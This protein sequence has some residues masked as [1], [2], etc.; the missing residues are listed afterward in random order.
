MKDPRRKIAKKIIEQAGYADDCTPN[1]VYELIDLMVKFEKE[2]NK[3]KEKDN[4]QN[5]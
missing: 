1:Y 5:V 4:K 3:L 2:V